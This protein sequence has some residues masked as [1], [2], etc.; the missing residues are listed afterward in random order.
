MKPLAFSQTRVWSVTCL[1][2]AIMATALCFA[3]VDPVKIVGLASQAHGQIGDL[4]PGGVVKP[5]D[6]R[7]E[8]TI[9]LFK[10]G[11]PGES[12]SVVILG[13]G[14]G[15]TQR[16]VYQE[17]REIWQSS[18]GG[19]GWNGIAG[20]FRSRAAGMSQAQIEGR[21][22][23][24]VQA[25]FQYY[26]QNLFLEYQW[27]QDGHYAIDAVDG[28]FRTR[29]LIDESSYLVTALEFE[30]GTGRDPFQD[31]NFPRKHRVEFGDY[32]R[33]QG[34]MTPFRT[35]YR[36]DGV[37]IEEIVLESAAYGAALEN[38]AGTR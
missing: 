29:Y 28:R 36:I 19:R 5:V 9:T 7:G 23:R 32:R 21:T 11:Q 15:R 2:V 33:V 6:W 35:V 8:G 3:Q 12:F 25:L 22:R 4:G 27:T 13:K 17:G 38:R 31:R 20:Q 1:A 18:D 14:D 30:F 24:S 10:N 26:E 37:R 16:I 34:V